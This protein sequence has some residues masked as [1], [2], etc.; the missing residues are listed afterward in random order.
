MAL[1][2]ALRYSG[3]AARVHIETSPFI[4]PVLEPEKYFGVKP[5]AKNNRH[6]KK[7]LTSP[8]LALLLEKSREEE[9][10]TRI[11]IRS[12]PADKMLTALYRGATNARMIPDDKAYDRLY[13]QRLHLSFYCW[14]NCKSSGVFDASPPISRVSFGTR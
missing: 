12:M 6:G 5:V 11:S 14:R 4:R 1:T 3:I 13:K 10:K 9:A 7:F 8:A 2:E